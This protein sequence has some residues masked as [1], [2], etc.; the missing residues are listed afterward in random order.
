M[1]EPLH[2]LLSRES[3]ARTTKFVSVQRE[4]AEYERELQQLYSL[5]GAAASMDLRIPM[6]LFLLDCARLNEVSRVTEDGTTR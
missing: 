5:S 3:D 2:Y 6:E 1:Y 4:L